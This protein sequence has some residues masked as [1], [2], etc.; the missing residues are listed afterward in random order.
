MTRLTLRH[1]LMILSTASCLGPCSQEQFILIHKGTHP[2]RRQC[3]R[4]LPST[5]LCRRHGVHWF[6][7][8]PRPMATLARRNTS[9][10]KS[11]S[12]TGRHYSM[13]PLLRPPNLVRERTHCNRCK[14]KLLDQAGQPILPMPVRQERKGEKARLRPITIARTENATSSLREIG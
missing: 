2:P 7:T 12:R 14:H 9:L 3:R 5:C 11:L 6:P 13:C 10:S 4:T 1:R 8:C